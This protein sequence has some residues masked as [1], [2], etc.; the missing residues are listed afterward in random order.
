MHVLR[1]RL[2]V[3]AGFEL[4]RVAEA[5]QVGC[6]DAA[7]FSK[8][9]HQRSPHVAVLRVAMQKDDRASTLAGNEVVHS[10]AV[11]LREAA[12]NLLGLGRSGRCGHG[13]DDNSHC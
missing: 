11:R 3:V 10:Q 1:H 9:R 7:G 6:D 4:H 5:A 13:R 8:L 12:F 2:L